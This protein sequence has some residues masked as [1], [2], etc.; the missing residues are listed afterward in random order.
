MTGTPR[1]PGLQTLNFTDTAVQRRLIRKGKRLPWPTTASV[2]LKQQVWQQL[3]MIYKPRSFCMVSS[4]FQWLRKSNVETSDNFSTVPLSHMP[5][6]TK[7]RQSF[8]CESAQEWTWPH[9]PRRRST[10]PP[11]FQCES[12]VDLLLDVSPAAPAE[13]AV[14]AAAEDGA[15]EARCRRGISTSSWSCQEAKHLLDNIV[16][17]IKV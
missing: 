15:P 11:V 6:L 1:R 10:V 3:Y 14:P 8:F 2:P 5:P 17:K 12:L 4:Y 7:A 16:K 13:L 9:N